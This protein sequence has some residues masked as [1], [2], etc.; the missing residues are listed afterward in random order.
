MGWQGRRNSPGVIMD[1][2]SMLRLVGGGVIVAAT[3]PLTG[4]SYFDV[5]ASALAAWQPPAADLDIRRW[6]LSHALLA[7]NPHNMQPWVADLRREGEVL[8]RFDGARLLPATD[9]YGRQI[10]MGGGA[11]L[12]VLRMAAAQ[13]GYRADIEVFP[14]GASDTALDGRPFARIRLVEE[15]GMTTDPLFSQVFKRRTDRQAYDLSRP[16]SAAD[17]AQLKDSVGALQV[18]FGLTGQADKAKVES[19]RAIARAAWRSELLTEAPFMES[20]RVLRVGSDEIDRFRDGIS[21][22]S[23][24]L[25]MLT[26]LGL[27]DRSKFP[28]PDSQ[29]VTGQI[30]TFDE[31]TASTPSYLWLVTEGNSRNSQIEA[32]R[33]YVRAN[34]AGT[35]AGLAMH[36]NEQALQEYREVADSYQAIHALLDAS[37]PAHTVQMLARVGYLPAGAMP[38]APAPR[39]GLS[40]HVQT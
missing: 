32:G 22:T 40:A 23:P 19:I 11:F 10:V 33:A 18:R 37:R 7:P 29:A 6:V 36:P 26:K 16:V 27:F 20:M 9:P 13:R 8:L 24:M 5:P 4:C 2:R 31:I 15:K 25:V 39:R 14:E 3:A 28:A 1:R 12:E 21:I 17:A 38:A 34:L 35:A 30:R